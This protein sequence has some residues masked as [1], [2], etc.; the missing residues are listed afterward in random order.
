MIHSKEI[1][2]LN[3]SL[4]GFVRQ[5]ARRSTDAV[6][7]YF[8]LPIETLE[9]LLCANSEQFERL[10]SE[11]TVF[12]KPK[13]N[14]ALIREKLATIS[15]ANE[16]STFGAES[17]FAQLWWLSLSKMAVSDPLRSAQIFGV[18]VEF[19]RH[20]GATPI[21]HLRQ[22]SSAG[23]ASFALRFEPRHIHTLLS[24]QAMPVQLF[25]KVHQQALSGAVVSGGR[26]PTIPNHPAIK[27][28]MPLLDGASP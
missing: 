26:L 11:T 12:F 10:V 24:S 9:A 28:P 14:E 25:L 6:T 13:Q 22:F 16:C 3:T 17:E 8:G 1:Y 7:Q 23:C 5:A 2:A 27:P 20:I 4:W 21:Q 19:A 15:H 18:S